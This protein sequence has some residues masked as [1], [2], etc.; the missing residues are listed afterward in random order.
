MDEP[1]KVGYRRTFETEWGTGAN[2]TLV[3]VRT[4]MGGV[5]RRHATDV[6]TLR[7]RWW[8]PDR[9]HGPRRRGPPRAGREGGDLTRPDVRGRDGGASQTGRVGRDG[10][11]LLGLVET[12]AG[13][14]RKGTRYR[15]RG[16]KRILSYRRDGG[17]RQGSRHMTQN[18]V[19]LR[20]YNLNE[21]VKSVKCTMKNVSHDKAVKTYIYCLEKRNPSV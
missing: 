20:D 21:V 8:K 3:L 19:V 15:G 10:G 5:G 14:R 17:V 7:S 13:P 6:M 2:P 11:D 9:T 18:F 16:G 1:Q 4:P 12:E